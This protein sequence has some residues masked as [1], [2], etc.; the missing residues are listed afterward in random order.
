MNKQYPEY[1]IPRQ[2]IKDRVFSQ[3]P[4]ALIIE[5][6]LVLVAVV[7]TIGF[8]SPA[9]PVDVVD[10]RDA[11][12]AELEATVAAQ[13]AAM[14]EAAAAHR[15][16]MAEAA[17][18]PNGLLSASAIKYIAYDNLTNE[19]YRAAIGMYNIL[20]AEGEADINT[21]LARGYAYSQIDEHALAARDYSVVLRL[22]ANNLG[23]LNNRCW[24]LNEIGA[25]AAAIADCNRLIELASEEAYPYLNR[26]IAY[27]KMGN[28]RAAMSDY[29]EW[30]I[31]NGSQA[32]RN[33]TLSWS[34]SVQVEMQE[35]YVYIFPVNLSAGQDV[36]VTAISTQRGVDADP[37]LL[38]MDPNGSNL[39]ANDDSGQW[40]DS[41]VQFRA[42]MSGEYTVV[43][44][45]AG[46]SSEGR[47]EVALDASGS[48][49]AGSDIAQYKAHAYRAMMAG[50]YPTALRSFRKALTLNPR[51]AEAMNWL[52]VT[53][54]HMGEYDAALNH[55]NMAMRLDAS[56]TLPYLSRG[57][58]YEAMGDVQTTAA[59]FYRYMLHNRT[60]S[61]NHEALEGDS[62][63]ALPMRE[64]WIYG[65]PFTARAG[66][67]IDIDV[68]TTE[69]G[70][71]DPLIVL[72]GPDGQ[73]LVADD[74]LSQNQFDASIDGYALP[75]DGQ[76]ILAVSHAEGG[77][78]GIINV[79]FDI[80]HA[81][82]YGCSG[83]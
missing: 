51:D 81:R 26:G 47:V 80:K 19:E 69:P 27:E 40:W 46:G 48:S 76:Y 57:M 50:D 3:R 66:Q 34:D 4:S 35:G 20:I 70:F 7:V 53:Y 72:L 30:V 38:V 67:R 55:I 54:R 45:H 15:A 11:T 8:L 37:L 75:A 79:D 77:A 71:V 41:I 59:D 9:E 22:D 49:E 73:P 82:G 52:G 78:N 29:M 10:E 62:Q 23:A 43:L 1:D 14:A 36:S 39:T 60:L 44:T 32:V 28:M 5:G 24:A 65:I 68:S 31:R 12:I 56:Y 17:A 18:A 33:E 42:P 6:L 74:D 58:T 21:Y 13:Q 25:Y 2:S 16:A 83:P 61:F 64:G 63:F